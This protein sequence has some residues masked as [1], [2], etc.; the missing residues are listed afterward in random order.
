MVDKDQT[1]DDQKWGVESFRKELGKN[2]ENNEKDE[3]EFIEMEFQGLK[4]N[5]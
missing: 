5:I 1:R 4:G 2:N 3:I